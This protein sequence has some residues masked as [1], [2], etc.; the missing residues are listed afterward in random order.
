[1]FK[2]VLEYGG[3]LPQ[4]NLRGNCCHVP[5]ASDASVVPFFLAYR[6]MRPL[7]MRKPVSF[8]A[9]TRQGSHKELMDQGG[10]CRDFVRVRGSSRSWSRRKAAG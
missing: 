8:G 2:K 7:L 6:I 4:N 9:A 1:L 3:G 5:G 10:I